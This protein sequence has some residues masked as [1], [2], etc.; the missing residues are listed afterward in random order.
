MIPKFLTDEELVYWIMHKSNLPYFQLFLPD[1]PYSLM[2]KEAIA[3]KELFVSHRDDDSSQEEYAHKG[4]RSVCIHGES[5]DR[6]ESYNEYPDNQ[7]KTEKDINY[8]WCTEVVDNCPE[9]LRY[10]K[11]VFPQ[12]DYRRLRFMWLDPHGYI[13]PHID[14]PFSILGPINISLNNPEGCEFKMEN[15]GIVPFKDEGSAFVMNL[16]YAHSVTN[17]SDIPRIHIISHGKPN[18]NF[19]KIVLDSYKMYVDQ[20]Y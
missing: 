9:T 4:W 19:N 6:T 11:E 13:Q 3:I 8:K 2:L 15:V 12:Q 7:G 16:S 5:Y 17:N 18:K 14:F 1:C 20:N 10:F